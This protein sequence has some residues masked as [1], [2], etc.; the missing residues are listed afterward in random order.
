MQRKSSE[1]PKPSM[2]ILHLEDDPIDTEL[3]CELLKNEEI[4]AEN[5]SHRYA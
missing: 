4:C 3:V 5:R 1:D 2:R